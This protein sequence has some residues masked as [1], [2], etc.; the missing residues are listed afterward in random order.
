MESA[1]SMMGCMFYGKTEIT[2]HYLIAFEQQH[3]L[4]RFGKKILKIAVAEH[5]LAV[6]VRAGKL[7]KMFGHWNEHDLSAVLIDKIDKVFPAFVGKLVSYVV[8]H[9]LVDIPVIYEK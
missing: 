5:C 2:C 3:L 4:D 7:V 1:V 8:Y 6:A 9:Y